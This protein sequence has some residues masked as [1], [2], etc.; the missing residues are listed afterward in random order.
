[1]QDVHIFRGKSGWVYLIAANAIVALT[2]FSFL[3]AGYTTEAVVTLLNGFAVS[4]VIWIF[5]IMP[6]IVYNNR[7]IEIHNPFTTV[8]VP[9]TEVVGLLTKYSFTI[10]T[11][12]AKY[13]SWA[14]PAPSIFAARRTHKAD[15]KSRDLTSKTIVTPSESP[16]SASGAAYILA[17]RYQRSIQPDDLGRPVRSINWISVALSVCALAAVAYNFVH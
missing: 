10:Q 8:K 16:N 7:R 4:V 9:W 13:S 3:Q 6:K 12:D 15:F 11:V 1:M 2:F 14:A 5:L 17:M